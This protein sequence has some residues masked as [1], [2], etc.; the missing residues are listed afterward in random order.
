VIFNSLS[1][2]HIFQ[3]I[4]IMLKEVYRRISSL[5][6]TLE[7]TEKAKEF[8]AER[9]YDSKYG[10]RPLQRAIQKYLED[11]LAEELLNSS[12]KSGDT[13]IVDIDPENA[14]KLKTAIKKQPKEEKMDA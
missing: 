9:G 6:F 14:E 4:D 2:E 3:I 8:I 5:G 1:K 7:I 10:A 13:V 12:M 11:P